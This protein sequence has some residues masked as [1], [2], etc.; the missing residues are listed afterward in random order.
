MH[1]RE[2][3][4]AEQPPFLFYT[5]IDLTQGYE[6]F[7]NNMAVKDVQKFLGKLLK[8]KNCIQVIMTVPEMNVK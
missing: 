3:L 5:G 1:K 4:L 6:E 7:I 8:Q 2:Q